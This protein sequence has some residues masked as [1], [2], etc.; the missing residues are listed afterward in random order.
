MNSVPGEQRW[1]AVRGITQDVEVP[2]WTSRGSDNVGA[3][4]SVV[5]RWIWVGSLYVVAAI[6]LAFGF[7][8]QLLW[9][10]PSWVHQLCFVGA[11]ACG[12]AGSWLR[13]RGKP[14]PT[15]LTSAD[16][17]GGPL[18]APRWNQL[19]TIARWMRVISVTLVCVGIG[20]ATLMYSGIFQMGWPARWAIWL[21]HHARRNGCA[22]GSVPSECA[23]PGR[24]RPIL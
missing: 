22:G 3:R 11:A 17:T 19:D 4:R 15:E 10:G 9:H 6:V 8:A 20:L 7:V 21:G 16:G 13:L 12:V 1:V 14:V 18:P 23:P 2:E 24:G 5:R